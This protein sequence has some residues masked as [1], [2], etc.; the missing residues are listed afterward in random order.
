MGI[1]VRTN[2]MIIKILSYSLLLSAAVGGLLS[3][4]L[5]YTNGNLASV[6]SAV[7]LPFNYSFSQAGMLHEAANMNVSSSPYWW[8]NS[9]G[10]IRVG[11]GTGGTPIG[12]LPAHT[13]WR[14]LYSISNPVD[15]D[16]GYRPQNIFRLVGRSQWQD[17]M[18]TMY[19]K[20]EKTNLSASPN[21]NAS[22]GILLFTRYTDGN[23][24][25]YA[26]IRV[27]G[28]AVIKKKKSGSYTTLGQKKIIPGVWNSKN[29]PNLLPQKT[30]IGIRTITKNEGNAVRVT[31]FTDV[32]K[33]GTWTEVLSVLDDGTRGG[34]ALTAAGYGGVRT[35][36]MDVSFDDYQ[37]S[38]IPQ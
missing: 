2:L 35:D 19:F 17:V 3:S 36:F 23:N 31:M 1:M 15:T 4:S 21:R 22:N 10:F 33:T 13:S 11:N 9:G 6:A 29:T 5:L 26:G 8:V 38:E 12:E 25:Y 7:L 18:Q 32:G 14:K 28:N 27:D 24:L 20:V 30:W 34:A 16:N 37:L